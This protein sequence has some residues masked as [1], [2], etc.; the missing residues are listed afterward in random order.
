MEKGFKMKYFQSI[1]ERYHQV[2]KRLKGKILDEFCKVCG[3]RRKYAIAKLNGGTIEERQRKRRIATRQRCRPIT[4][5]DQAINILGKV[6]EAANY[7]CSTRLKSILRLWLP[8]LEKHYQIKAD[9]REQLLKISPRQ[10][11]RRLQRKKFKAKRR[12]YGGTKP[13]TLL[14]HQIPIKTDHWDV[15]EAGFTEIDTVSHSGNSAAGIF[16]YSVNLTD[17][18]SGWVETRAILG[19][20]EKEI[21]GTI[22][23]IEQVLPFKLRGLDSDNGSEFINNHL[24][25]LCERKQI[26]FTRGRPY[27]KNDNAHIEQKNWTHVRKIFGWSRYDTLRAVS[28]MND[29]YRNELRLFMNL[30]LPSTKLLAK[31]RVGSQTRR[32]YDEPKTPLDRLITT[33]QGKP[34]EIE[35]LKVLRS[36][37]D[38][39]QLSRII[40]DKIE[41]IIKLANTRQSPKKPENTADRLAALAGPPQLSSSEA[42]VLS[43]IEKMFGIPV[44]MA[45]SHG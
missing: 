30:F 8:W 43:Q 34:A 13:G 45:S 5:S 42:D 2:S 29:L 31:K 11:D 32:R 15:K 35:R 18:L 38:P 26:Q 6:W 25:R 24:R 20:G 27:K 12:L 33:G 14:K 17:I 1:Y 4:Y 7:P 44:E 28:A 22:E 19:K 37:L 16:V 9:I 36:Q 39:F 10:M 23:E 40:D 21:G 3:Y 41:R